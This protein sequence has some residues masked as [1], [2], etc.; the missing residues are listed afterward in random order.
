M[1][2]A[3]DHSCTLH[4]THLPAR[5]DRALV[6]AFPALSRRRIRRALD[7]GGIYLN[8]RRVRI[9]S[10]LVF[11]GDAVA[12]FLPP[13]SPRTSS[14]CRADLIHCDTD[15]MIINKPPCLLSQ[16]TR[17]QAVAHLIPAIRQL[18]P[19]CGTLYI[20]HRLDYETS[21]AIMVARHRRIA[22]FLGQQ[23]RTRRIAKEYLALCAGIPPWRNYT[24]RSY[25]SPIAKDYGTVKIATQPQPHTRE[26][27]TRFTVLASSS[28]YPVSL[29]KCEPLSGR[30]HQLR[31][32]LQHLGIPVLGDKKYGHT[33]PS[34]PA[35]A[36]LIASHHLL[37]AHR[38]TLQP[39]RG[40]T[41]IS[42]QAQPPA[43]FREML[44]LLDL[45][46]TQKSCKLIL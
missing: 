21:G 42:I 22:D 37:H 8:H 26:A 41:R 39:A 35:A 12:I 4:G 28:A 45:K 32:Q 19:A 43:D 15:L 1:I 7:A 6:V 44:T 16:A 25:L 40:K 24:A 10:R 9:A 30:S 17:Q 5:I 38:L 18:L 20:V 11:N 14:L 29:L 46:G 31:A 3:P 2:P 13:P 27:V 34:L 36:A 33:R 23:L